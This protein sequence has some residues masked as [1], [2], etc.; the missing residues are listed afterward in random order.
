VKELIVMTEYEQVAVKIIVSNAAIK[1]F[2]S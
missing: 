2:I 1:M